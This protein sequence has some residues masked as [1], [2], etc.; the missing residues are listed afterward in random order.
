MVVET[1]NDLQ[2]PEGRGSAEI[3]VGAD[4]ESGLCFVG[5]RESVA[6]TKK[7]PEGVIL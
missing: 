6:I 3:A 7:M 4:N 2:L 1:R 5:R